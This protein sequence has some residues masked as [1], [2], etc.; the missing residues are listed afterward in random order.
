MGWIGN[1]GAIASLILEIIKLFKSSKA[2]HL[3]TELKNAKSP[4]EKQLSAI[5]ISSR[6]YR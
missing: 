3:F 6:L 4:E 2:D 1:I 5:D